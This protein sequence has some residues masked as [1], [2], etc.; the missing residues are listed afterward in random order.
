M[1]G[2]LL[3]E[4]FN[5]IGHCDLSCS[6]V[7]ELRF[8][9]DKIHEQLQ[10]SYCKSNMSLIPSRSSKANRPGIYGDTTR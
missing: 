5:L 8:E 4:L 1:G 9:R 6:N 7:E 2:I 10:F 3:D